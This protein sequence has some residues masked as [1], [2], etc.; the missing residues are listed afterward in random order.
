M[1]SKPSSIDISVGNMGFGVKP[2]P[3]LRTDGV[4]RR[5]RLIDLLHRNIDS[6]VQVISA[7]AGYGKTTLLVDFI[8]DLDIP[9]CWYSL[10]ESD[11]DPRIFMEGLSI[12]VQSQFPNF[13]YQSDNILLPTFE[14]AKYTAKLVASFT[15]ELAAK[16]SE[17][18]IFVIED[19]HFIENN[20]LLNLAFDLLLNNMP[21]NCHLI[22]SS[23]NSIELPAL[24]RL[25]V[26]RKANC[27]SISDISFTP[28]EAKELLVTYYSINLSDSDSEKLVN[29]TDGWIVGIILRANKIRDYAR[30]ADNST[31]LSK[32][33]VFDFLLSEVYEKQAPEIQNFLLTSSILDIIDLDICDYLLKTE[34]SQKFLHN[35]I[36]RQLFIQYIDSEKPCY[37]Y[38]H[39]FREFLQQ[40]LLEENPRRFRMLNFEVAILYEKAQQYIKAVQHFIP[41]KEYNGVIRIINSA[42]EELLDTGKWTTL[43]NWINA[44]PKDL[45]LA[46]QHIIMLH[47]RCLIYAGD[48]NV[49]IGILNSLSDS[50]Q[51]SNDWLFEAR[52]LS[53]RSAAYRLI[54]YLKEAEK[55][56]KAS[57]PIFKKN[58]GPS[59]DTGDAYRR[60]GEILKEQG[61]PQKALKQLQ[62]SLKYYTMT[63]NVSRLAEVHNSIGIIYK[64]LGDLDTAS[65]HFEK[66]RIGWQKV[67][68]NGAL[69]MTLTNIAE[70][71]H[72]RGEYELAL[73]TLQFGLEKARQAGYR[74]IESYI[75]IHTAE[76][77]HS[78]GLYEDAIAACNQGLELA[79]QVMETRCIAWAKADMAEN[80]R[81]LGDLDKAETLVKEAVS[82]ADENGHRCDA[83]QFKIQIGI[84]EYERGNYKTAIQML[85]KVAESLENMGDKYAL[86]KANLH[87]A[88]AIFIS[89]DYDQALLY[90]KNL[91]NLCNDLGYYDFIAVEG[92]K[93]TPLLQYSISNGIGG[94]SFHRAVEKIFQ[95]HNKMR[96]WSKEDTGQGS[97]TTKPDIEVHSL[98]EIEVITYNL[99][100]E[101]Q[102]RSNKAKELFLYLLCTNKGR[103]SEQIAAALWPDLS[104]AKAIGNFH[105][106]L[107]RARRAVLPNLFILEDGKYKINRNIR[108]WLDVT[109]FENKLNLAFNP[110]CENELRVASLEQAIELYR[111]DFMDG[112]F[113]E[114]V[115]EYRRELE[116]RYIRALS[117]L[118][119]IKSENRE[120]DSAIELMV[121]AIKV[122]Q[123][124][125][126][127]YCKIIEWQMTKGDKTSAITTYHRYLDQIVREMDISPSP[128]IQSLHQNMLKEEDGSKGKV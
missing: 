61:L 118:A 8:N 77:K 21:D 114:W 68:N 45:Y 122:N 12:S 93:C 41:A 6:C 13:Y 103:T 104:P 16:V 63:L 113:S 58:N 73:N 100:S 47:A 32:E 124:N 123:F 117:V 28:T 39:I 5:Q 76:V 15:N 3:P 55:D 72:R 128:K 106:N 48:S 82:F 38:H 43:L 42:G 57:I 92:R 78:Q 71:Y 34:Y 62:R 80:Y 53:W 19:Y 33:N 108:I 79:R 107:Y 83:M 44:L 99:I 24:S 86:A 115:L 95:F 36:R 85:G 125:E 96:E 81:L 2:R 60:L 97:Y 65:M 51:G 22:I 94:E 102:W 31:P 50:V 37:R 90:L 88:Q 105:V 35:V 75:Q 116:D 70:I 64:D 121:K 7:P 126:E 18:T 66:S 120:Y 10:D 9:V 25:I 11:R 52:I 127:A 26:Q 59:L 74:R 91:V 87:L 67:K 23:R 29:E 49:A 27:L 112:F 84:I 20:S 54:G 109:E 40:K 14:L 110:R 30:I 1:V 17:Y 46:D 4:I 89:R 101:V 111:G 56:I 119:R 98:G 69:A